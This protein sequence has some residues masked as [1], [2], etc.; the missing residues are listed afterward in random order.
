MAKS[1]P[2]LTSIFA[3]EAGQSCPA[4]FVQTSDGQDCPSSSREWIDAQDSTLA[5]KSFL[6]R[7]NVRRPVERETEKILLSRIN[8]ACSG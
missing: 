2:A 6:G 3:L 8:H 5:D 4:Y 7:I 1:C